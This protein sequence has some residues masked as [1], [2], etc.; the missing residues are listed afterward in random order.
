VYDQPILLTGTTRLRARVFANNE[1]SALVE[2]DYAREEE[3]TAEI[4]EIARWVDGSVQLTFS[5]YP[6]VQYRVHT[7]TNLTD[8]T[9]LATL[10]PEPG[11][12]FTYLDR[13]AAG[14]RVRF[15]KLSWP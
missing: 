6:G 9:P 4:R 13:A 2:A 11:G 1:W 10:A 15:Y 5:G 12:R 3:A 8:W 7:S 14:T